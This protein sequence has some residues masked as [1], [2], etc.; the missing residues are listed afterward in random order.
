MN[1]DSDVF[2]GT[3][4]WWHKGNAN[5]AGLAQGPFLTEH[6]ARCAYIRANP[7][8]KTAPTPAPTDAEEMPRMSNFQNIVDICGILNA[9][10]PDADT[11]AGFKVE[12]NADEPVLITHTYFSREKK[13]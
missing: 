3:G 11:L 8:A 7:P 6:L 5:T 4:G 9:A 13:K 1:D 2:S 10:V 12:F